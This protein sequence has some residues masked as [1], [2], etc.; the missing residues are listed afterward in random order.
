MFKNDKDKKKKSELGELIEMS[1]DEI[2]EMSVVSDVCAQFRKLLLDQIAR[3]TRLQEAEK[4]KKDFKNLPVS[5]IGIAPGDGIGPNISEQAVRV[6]QYLLKDQIAEGKVVLKN[7]EG[8]TIENRIARQQAVPD[9]VMDEIKTCDV[10]LKGPTTTLRGGNLES[11]NVAI[12]RELDLYANVRPVSVP[13]QGIDWIFFRE[14]TEDLYAVGSRGIEIPGSLAIDFKVITEPGTKRIARAAYEY[15][16]ANGKT[17]VNIV[18]KANILK[19]TDGNFSR[20]CHE[21]AKAYPSLELEDYYVDIMTAKLLDEKKRKS[22]Q[23]FVLPN[24][25]GDIITDEAAEIQGGVGTAGSSNIGDRYAMF[26]AIHGSADRMVEE[27]RGQYANPASLIKAEAMMLRHIGYTE[28]AA[29]ID[30]ALHICC[31]VEKKVVITGHEDGATSAEFTDYLM[32]K[33]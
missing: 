32:S 23:V 5:T 15:A 33:L 11:A 14:N 20:I 2:K 3:A 24:L 1:R 30:E 27:G 26:E 22:F 9:D 19:K 4:E 8:L 18:T 29:K 28:E 17:H 16:V 25:Y 12:R 13:E 21:M 31:D 6:L 7:I 10:L